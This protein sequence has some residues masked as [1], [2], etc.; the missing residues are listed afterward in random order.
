MDNLQKFRQEIDAIDEQIHAL[1]CQRA[2]IAVT[3]REFKQQQH[4]AAPFY[5][6]EREAQVLRA[7]QQK[8]CQPLHSR[9]MIR[10]FRTIM[11][12]C[13]AVQE[14]IK[15]AFLGPRGTFS[16][17]AAMEHFG[18]SA[19]LTPAPTIEQVFSV[20][21]T[22]QAHYGVVPVE[23]ST[24]GVIDAVIHVFAKNSVKVCGEI[25]I[26]IHH[27]FLVN[28]HDKTPITAIMSH[29]QS[30]LQCQRWLAQHYPN[31]DHIA[32]SSN[33]EAARQAQ[34]QLG[35]AA[36][37]GELAKEEYHLSIA[38][39]NIEDEPNNVTR[40]LVIG[41][42]TTVPSGHDRTSL[43]ITASDQPGVL[44]RMINPFG[45]NH[46]NMTLIKSYLA[47]QQR[48]TYLFYLECDGHV[49]EMPL[50]KAL[51]QLQNESM[52]I[53]ILGSYPKAVI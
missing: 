19:Q 23:N 52:A 31:V 39:R 49:Q 21:N 20:V 24:T 1:V 53:R 12:A 37:A 9:D 33:A 47:S 18:P 15:I 32:V 30:L 2:N 45:K 43:L 42:Q 8:P 26:P 14:P 4:T 40:F 17:M 44:E 51:L 5:R 6:P 46:V 34:L 38:A 25:S 28:A 27:H 16:Q 36:I 13:L 48:N 41:D 7:I 35:I 3:V 29:Q 50:Q 22:Q 10:I 11:S